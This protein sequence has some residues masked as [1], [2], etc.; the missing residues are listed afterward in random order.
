MW[1]LEKSDLYCFMLLLGAVIS[2]KACLGLMIPWGTWKFAFVVWN[3]KWSQILTHSTISINLLHV[4]LPYELTTSLK[5]QRLQR[6]TKESR[7][8]FSETAVSRQNLCIKPVCCRNF[9]FSQITIGSA[10][11]EVQSVLLGLERFQNSLLWSKIIRGLEAALR[12]MWINSVPKCQNT[13]Y[14]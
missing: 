12:K 4:D 1:K 13:L 9:I 8:S 5:E 11:R 6:I 14:W 3:E 10:G 7:E 2:L